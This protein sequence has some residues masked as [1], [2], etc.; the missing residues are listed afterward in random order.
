M[1]AKFQS[2]LKSASL[3][4]SH[5]SPMIAKECP[6]SR[7][8]TAHMSMAGIQPVP[9]A[10]PAAKVKMPAPATLLTRL[11]T[12]AR[13]V[14]FASSW[15]PPRTELALSYS[16]ETGYSAFFVGAARANSTE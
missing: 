7:P 3:V 16:G 1:K 15:L 11:K 8:K 13:I 2:T 5:A 6:L 10:I 9:L 4:S 12:D 14:A